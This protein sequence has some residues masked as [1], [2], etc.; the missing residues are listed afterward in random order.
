MPECTTCKAYC[1]RYITVDLPKPVSPEDFD[2]IRWYVLHKNVIVYKTE[3]EKNWRVEFQTPC[4]Y[5]DEKKYLCKH[6]G[7]RPIVCREYT[8]DECGGDRE[9]TSDGCD[10]YLENELDLKRYLEKCL[11][12]IASLVF[13]YWDK[14]NN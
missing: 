5:L 1:C 13:R 4:E 3:D 7:R 14:K 2:E 12:E 11:P 8:T 10:V 9:L 6:Y